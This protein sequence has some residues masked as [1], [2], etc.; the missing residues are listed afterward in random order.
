MSQDPRQ[1]D[2]PKSV[3]VELSVDPATLCA[4]VRAL[5]L[6]SYHAVTMTADGHLSDSPDSIDDLLR[7]IDTLHQQLRCLLTP[8]SSNL[9]QWA[10]S[11]R[12]RIERLRDGTRSRHS[13]QWETYG[14]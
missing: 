14:P 10:D 3:E 8:G 13:S 6:R 4:T 2:I 12:R 9:Q 1:A 11:L 5:A 7:Q